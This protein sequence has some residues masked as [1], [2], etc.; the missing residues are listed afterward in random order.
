[1]IWFTCEKCE[2]NSFQILNTTFTSL[3][4]HIPYHIQEN[5]PIGSPVWKSL[6][7]FG[8]T[9]L[10]AQFLMNLAGRYISFMNLCT[11]FGKDVNFCSYTDLPDPVLSLP[12]R[13]STLVY[14]SKIDPFFDIM[15]EF[16]NSL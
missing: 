1:M 7:G 14:L 10:K 5:I 4:I 11:V 2:N 13:H 6:R 9:P 12:H 15:S 8:M 3:T 16:G